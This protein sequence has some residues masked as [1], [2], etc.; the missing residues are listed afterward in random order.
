MKPATRYIF[1]VRSRNKDWLSRTSTFTEIVTTLDKKPNL[2]GSQR[3]KSSNSDIRT[4][5]ESS[6]VKLIDVKPESSSTVRTTWQVLVPYDALE[7]IHIRYRPISTEGDPPMS[8]LNEETINFH[9]NID[10]SLL[11]SKYERQI[12]DFDNNEIPFSGK[13]PNKLA[14]ELLISSHVVRGLRPGTMYELFIVPFYRKIEGVPSSSLRRTTLRA[15]LSSF[16]SGLYFD[17]VNAT[18]ARFG[19]NTLPH[20]TELGAV[21]QGYNYQVRSS[22]CSKLEN[23]RRVNEYCENIEARRCYSNVL[24]A[25]QTE[26][27]YGLSRYFW[28]NGHF[29]VEHYS[30]FF[31]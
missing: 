11:V 12:G 4:L 17:A 1:A 25:L 7:G 23:D 27:V 6:T 22:S 16:P 15:P 9:Q 20:I 13:Y 8:V 10:R 2:S 26:I 19:W 31:S 28:T 29:T 30:R 24:L 21:L 18:T 14:S 5:L 3:V